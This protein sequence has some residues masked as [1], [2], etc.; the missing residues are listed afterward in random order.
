MPD[1]MDDLQRQLLETF[2]AEAQEHLQKLNETLLQLERQPDEAVRYSLLQEVF[3]AAHSLKG[4]ARVVS[5]GDI[6]DLAHVMENV[7]QRARDSKLA[8]NP[9]VCDALYDAVDAIQQMLNGETIN[10]QPLSTRLT[11]MAAGKPVTP[12]T[13]TPKEELPALEQ[14]IVPGEETIRVAVSKLDDLMAQAGELTMAGI[15]V[16]QHLT[17]VRALR[18]TMARWPKLWRE[19]KTLSPHLEGDSGRR[20][21]DLLSQYHE[22]IQTLTREVT[23]LEQTVA[24]D[25]LNLS[26]SMS[27][28]Q[29]EVRRVRMVPLQTLA[30]ALQRAVRDAGRSEGKRV[31]F[32]LEGGEVELDKKVLETLKDPLLH[33]L[34]NAV[35]HGI[36][37]PDA[38]IAAGKSAEGQISLTVQQQGSEVH[39]AVHDDGRGFDVEALR[40]NG[41]ENGGPIFTSDANPNDIIAALAFRPGVTTMT[42]VTELAG[43]GVGLDVVRQN[44]VALRGRIKVE[45]TPGEGVT[46]LLIVPVSLTMSRGLLVR[47]GPERYAIPLIS[48]EKIVEV[49]DT[50]TIGGQT[51]LQVGDRPLPLVFLASILERPLNEARNGKKPLAVIVSL[52]EQRLAVLVDDVLTEQELAVKALSSPLHSVRNVEGAALLAAGEPIVVLNVADL[53]ESAR[54]IPAPKQSPQDNHA[55]SAGPLAHILVVDDSITTRTLEK[56]ILEAAGYQ[57]TTAIDGL[58]ALDK[59]EADTFDLIVLDVQMPH[60]DGFALTQQL[61]ESAKYRLFPIVL[62]TSLESREDREQGMRVGADAYIVKRGFDQAELLKSI[63]RLLDKEQIADA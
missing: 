4:A 22:Y 36:E 16:E 29:D 52:A 26:M 28:L 40:R 55:E 8:L 39:L 30:P 47:V 43:R 59:L 46:I 32:T 13:V 9:D 49:Q 2:Q 12:S 19:I 18:E 42:Q 35:I 10:I 54:G 41:A 45:N 11:S 15:G 58:Q 51:A 21:A 25:A 60:L 31:A 38:R 48:V 63:E 3:R 24:R 34:R 50:F 53:I 7:L 14:S 1:A 44:V 5:Q 37:M 62:V 6:E 20:L 57:V 56:N 23:A 33:L 27:R 17:D 61:R